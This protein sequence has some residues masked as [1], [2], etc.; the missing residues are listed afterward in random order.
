MT[1]DDVKRAADEASRCD[2]QAARIRR[3]GSPDSDHLTLWG[4]FQGD[5]LISVWSEN[6]HERRES[7]S[8][9]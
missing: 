7:G 4:M 1:Y 2:R 3:A 9:H 8:A 6:A 5:A